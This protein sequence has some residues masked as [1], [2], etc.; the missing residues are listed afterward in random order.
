[1][2]N[3]EGEKA[4]PNADP[5][6][7]YQDIVVA[8]EE[9]S[10]I[11]NGQPSLH[12]RCLASLEIKEGE[13]VTH[14]GAGVGYYTAVL[15][16]LTSASGKV[17]AYEI[18][19]KLAQKAAHNLAHLAQVAVVARSGAEG[20]LPESDV[21]YITAGATAPL[22]L[23]IDALRPSGRLLF[24]LTPNGAGGKLGLGNMLLITRVAKGQFAARF[25]C[26]AMFIPCIGARD[27]EMAKRLTEAF[28]NGRTSKVC[29][30]RRGTLPDETCWCSGN[31]WWLSTAEG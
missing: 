12:T 11:N 27:E 31:G 15:A 20:A 5:T 4:T 19:E 16:A 17:W 9:E 1:M 29:S 10:G 22:D 18:R 24:P 25:V 21:I 30:L 26:P 2:Y 13:I 28:R 23:W 7:L 14:I 8:I 3:G 6:L